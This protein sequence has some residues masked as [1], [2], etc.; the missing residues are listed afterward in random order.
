MTKNTFVSSI[1]VLAGMLVVG[2]F[3]SYITKKIIEEKSFEIRTKYKFSNL[4][5]LKNKKYNSLIFMNASFLYGSVLAINEDNFH[6]DKMVCAY[7]DDKMQ[8]FILDS[9]EKKVL[10]SNDEKKKYNQNFRYLIKM[11][12]G[13]GRG[14]R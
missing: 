14:V 12:N 5:D 1:I 2:F 3:S 13:S 8:K 7:L 6:V 4:S 11:C 10:M 9:I